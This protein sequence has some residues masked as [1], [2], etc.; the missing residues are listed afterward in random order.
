VEVIA[1]VRRT[2]G[3]KKDRPIPSEASPIHF[4]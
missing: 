2:G 1:E 3:K 4:G